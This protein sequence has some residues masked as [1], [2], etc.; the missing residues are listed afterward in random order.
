MSSCSITDRQSPT[1]L[2]MSSG[3]SGD[4]ADL[5]HKGGSSALKLDGI[6]RVWGREG[7]LAQREPVEEAA[8]VEVPSPIQSPGRQGEGDSLHSQTPTQTPTPEPEQEKQ[9]LASSLFVG[10]ASQSSVSLMGKSEP[11]PQRFRRKAKGQELS[12]LSHSEIAPLCANQS[13]NLSACHVQKE[14][15]LILVVFIMNSS[16]SAIQQMLLQ[17][18]S[19]ELE[20][21]C[22]CDSPAGGGDKLQCSSGPV[23]SNCE[24]ACGSRRGGRDGILPAACW[25][26]SVIAVFI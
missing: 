22:L 7:Y 5:S 17:V 15:S 12:G 19:E 9:Q 10:L 24:E 1:L 11:M 21:S 20:V 23:F 25:D 26:V 16:E 18:D 3:L 13:L 14:D 6:K 2:S 4:S 8:Q